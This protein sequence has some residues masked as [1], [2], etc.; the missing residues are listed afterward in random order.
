MI[1]LQNSMGIQTQQIT[2]RSIIVKTHEQETLKE[3][4]DEDSPTSPAF[5]DGGNSVMMPDGTAEP[6]TKVTTQ[7][8]PEVTI[9]QQMPARLNS[10][11]RIH[12]ADLGK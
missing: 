7:M 6:V 8:S 11:S 10:T 9:L 3:Q 2:P 4:K 1:H 5:K 12:T